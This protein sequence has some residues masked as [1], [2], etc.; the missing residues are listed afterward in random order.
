MTASPP[1]ARRRGARLLLPIAAVAL[2]SVAPMILP[3]YWVGVLLIALL[4]AVLASN[5]DLCLGYAG[6][7]NWAHLAVFALGAY[8]AGVLSTKYGV[9]PWLCILAAAAVAMIAHALIA[10]PCLRVKGVYVALV[11]FAFAQVCYQLVLSMDDLTGGSRGMTFIPSIKIGGYSFMKDGGIGYYYLALGMFVVSTVFLYLV[12]RSNFGLSIR[13]LRDYEDYAVSRGVPL[14]RQRLLTF[15]L[16][17]AFAGAT[18]AVYTFYL[19]VAS[20]ELFSF[21]YIASLLSM[22]LIGGIGTLWG[23]IIGAFAMTFLS[24]AMNSLGPWNIMI[25]SALT[26]LV[27]LVYPAGIIG[28]VRQVNAWWRRRQGQKSEAGAADAACT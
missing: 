3:A 8:T 18:G 4:Y 27:L 21:S 7:F 14:A 20:P 13:A 25:V 22:V 26:V 16:S 1:K 24:Q 19:S 10:V 15:V 28:A 5:W 2:L 17:G 9:S 11:T 6:V 12:V 23:P